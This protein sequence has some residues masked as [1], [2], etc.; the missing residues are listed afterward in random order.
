LLD[1]LLRR[2]AVIVAAIHPDAVHGKSG[3]ADERKHRQ[4]DII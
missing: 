4:V 2:P 3:R 1:R